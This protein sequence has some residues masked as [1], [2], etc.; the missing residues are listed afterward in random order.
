M[1]KTMYKIKQQ[2]FSKVNIQPSGKKHSEQVR[3][4]KTLNQPPAERITNLSRGRPIMVGPLI[5][6][7]ILNGTLQKRWTYYLR[8]CINNRK[9]FTQQKWR[10]V[11]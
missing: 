1:P 6:E 4:E 2:D 7:K 10:S 11:P 9:C 8:N 5:D 3:I